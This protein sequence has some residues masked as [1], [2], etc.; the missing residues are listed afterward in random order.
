M[1]RLTLTRL[2]FGDGKP[3]SRL[4]FSEY[5]R[6]LEQAILNMAAMSDLRDRLKFLPGAKDM[7]MHYGQGGKTEIYTMGDIVKEFPAGAD[8]NEVAAA[9]E[10]HDS[11][12]VVVLANPFETS[13]KKLS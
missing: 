4:S 1:P 13:K 11:T 2:R 7:T 12:T 6:D 8:H 10:N 5:A 3:F 9:F